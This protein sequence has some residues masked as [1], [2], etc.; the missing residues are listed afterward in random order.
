MQN[1]IKRNWIVLD[2]FEISF[3]LFPSNLNSNI[4]RNKIRLMDNNTSQI[5]MW[6]K[7][8][9]KREMKKFMIYKWYFIADELWTKK[10]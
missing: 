3:N 2:H 7:Y 8:K 5:Y 6:K 10:M 4:Q 1:N 9:Y